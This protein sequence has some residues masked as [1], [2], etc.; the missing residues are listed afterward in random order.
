[1]EKDINTMTIADV[2]ATEAFDK[3][4][5]ARVDQFKG[6][7]DLKPVCREVLEL[8]L[9]D[10]KNSYAECV[11]GTCKRF[12]L[13]QRQFIRMMIESSLRAEIKALKRNQ[14]NNDKISKQ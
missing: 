7:K 9:E 2:M 13:V 5:Q 11:A 14:E 3:R 10:I 12:S 6:V 4:L 1:M 8:T